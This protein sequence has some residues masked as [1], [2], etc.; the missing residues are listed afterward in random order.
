S[1]GDV[2]GDGLHSYVWDAETRPTTIDTVT[3]TYDA[4][5]RMVGNKL[6]LMNGTST[7]VKGFAP[8]PAGATA[9]YNPSG[10]QYYRHP[11]WLGSS[12][13][14]STPSRAMY[15]DLAFAPFGEQYAQSGSTGVT[16]TSFAGNNEDTTTNLYDAQFREYGIQGRWPSPDPAGV[17][18]VDPS[19]PQSL[20]RYAYTLNNPLSYT[21][22]LGLWVG[23]CGYELHGWPDEG[24]LT[25][26][27]PNF[28][29]IGNRPEPETGDTESGPGGGSN[30]NGPANNGTPPPKN[31]CVADALKAGATNVGIDLLG[32]LPEAGGVARVVGHRAGY[33]G[34]VADNLGKNM[35]TAGTKTTGTLASAIG[36]SSSHWTTW[37]SAGITAAD[38]V[39][40]LSDFT[41][42]V[43]IAWDAGVTA[44]KVHQCHK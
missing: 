8:L 37:V 38:F 17:A 1:N 15:N 10:L 14:S 7:L 35:L 28:C 21:D 43:A 12:R 30:S 27:E 44:Y 4:L 2:L 36:F 32:F 18:A 13:F 39:P 5:E 24:G 29:F 3:V 25:W 41:T 31:P 26:Y 23:V 9:V 40:V 33:V 11:D 19:N 16:D 34:K 22:T 20:N 6:A 42:P